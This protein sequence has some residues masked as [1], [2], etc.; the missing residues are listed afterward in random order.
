MTDKDTVEK[1]SAAMKTGRTIINMP[2]AQG[3]IGD[4]YNFKLAPSLTLGCG[5]WCGNSVSENVGPK[6]LLNIK[7]VA[8]RRENML[9]FRVPEKVHFKYGSLGVAL[10]ELKDTNKKKAFIVTDKVLYELG[11][12]DK[13]AKVLEEIGVDFKVFMDVEP[14]PTLA[15]ATKGAKEMLSYGPDTII[16]VGSGSAMDAAQRVC[17]EV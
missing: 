14:D 16:A 3:A 13:V 6:N 4:L 10:R 11:Y 12:A 17:Q 5:S 1:F 9:W 7:S 2:S 8:E 15:T